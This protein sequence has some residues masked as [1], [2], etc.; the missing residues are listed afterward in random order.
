MYNGIV[1]LFTDAYF[2]APV[3]QFMDLM[4]TSGTEV[5][6]Y[7]NAFNSL[8]IFGNNLLN[9]SSS[10]HGSDLLYLFGPTMYK[11]FFNTDF[12]SYSETRFSENIKSIIG[13][14]ALYGAPKSLSNIG[15]WTVYSMNQKNFYEMHSGLTSP[16]PYKD[17]RAYKFWQNYLPYLSNELGGSSSQLPNPGRGE[18]FVT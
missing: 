16:S 18:Y 1:D 5:Y 4:A 17:G 13:D 7:I 15:A 2:D 14:F 11:K 6:F 12:Q 10:A 9:R 8:D 3:H